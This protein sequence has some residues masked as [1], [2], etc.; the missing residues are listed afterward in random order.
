MGLD[1]QE[2][3]LPTVNVCLLM[4]WVFLSTMTFV[5]AFWEANEQA[6][7]WYWVGKK[8]RNVERARTLKSEASDPDWQRCGIRTMSSPPI[9]MTDITN[10]S[11][12]SPFSRIILKMPYRLH[13]SI[14]GWLPISRDRI[15]LGE[16]CKMLKY[17]LCYLWMVRPWQIL[18]PFYIYNLSS[19][20][21][22]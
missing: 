14:I 12:Y 13:S 11:Q 5:S 9:P 15:L 19:V 6:G 18:I 21:G 20:K 3:M 2:L 1:G 10:W 22:G 4:S 8:C 16:T 7:Q 17:S